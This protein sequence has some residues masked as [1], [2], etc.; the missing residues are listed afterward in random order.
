[1]RQLSERWA[2]LAGV[3]AV[4]CSLVGVL[5]VLNQPQTKDSNAKITAYFADHSH[6]VQG[7]VSFFVYLAGIIFLLVFLSALRERLVAAEGQ[8]GR[9]SA[10]AFGAG[11]AALPLWGISMLLA[12]AMSFTVSESSAFT[13]DPNTY[14]LLGVVAYITWVIALFVSSVVVWATSAV[15]LKT[16]ALPRWYAIA[17]IVVGVVQLFGLFLFPFVAWW[18]WIIVTSVLLTTRRERAPA[19][20]AQPAV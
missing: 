3:L 11:I 15:A 1:M 10:L 2:P 9:L 14:R 13:V 19:T 17:G 16:R 20:I 5:H 4:V 8:S 7:A 12:N 18:L 6:R